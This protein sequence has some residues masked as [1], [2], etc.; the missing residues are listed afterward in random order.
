MEYDK[1]LGW[2]AEAGSDGKIQL[3]EDWENTSA[4]TYTY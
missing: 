2:W 4:G 3:W 1:L